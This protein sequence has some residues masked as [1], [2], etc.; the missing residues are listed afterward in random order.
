MKY[1]PEIDGLR[2]LAVLPVIFSHAGFGAFK[3]GYVGVDIFFVISGFLITSILLEENLQASF[4]VVRFYERRA[5]RILPALFL[6]MAV[7]SGLAW[8]SMLPDELENFGQSLFATSAF[9]NNV[10]LMFTAGYWSLASDFKPLLHTWSL[11]VEEQ[12]YIVFPLL[13]VACRRWSMGAL[14]AMFGSIAV[15]S[16]AA[17]EWLSLTRSTMA[18]YLLP[19]RAWELLFGSLVAVG[20]KEVWGASLLAGAREPLSFV[21]LI[22]VLGAI[23]SFG[24]SIRSPSLWLLVPTVGA[25][26][27]ILFAY[28]GTF[29]HRVLASKIAVA[30]GL[31]SYSAYL[32]HQPLFAFARILSHEKP[33]DAL[34]FG[35]CFATIALAYVSWRWVEQ[36]FRRSG[37]PFGR[38]FIFTG[39]FLGS[40]A[41]SAFG[42]F[43]HFGKGIPERVFADSSVTRAGMYIGYNERAFERKVEYFQR[44]GVSRVL[45]HGNSYARDFLNMNLEVFDTGS[46]E[47][48]YRD[49]FAPCL[50]KL[51]GRSARLY[52][53][54]DVIVYAS[55]G[56]G[57]EVACAQRNAAIANA[58]GK[59]I[60]Y[61]G[62]KHFGY[63]LNWLARVPQAERVLQTNA[64]VPAAWDEASQ[65]RATVPQEIFLPIYER[66]IVQDRRMPITD[67][68]GRILSPDRVHLTRDGAVYLGRRVLWDTAYEESIGRPGRKQTMR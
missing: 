19:T 37:S 11:G 51:E 12:F 65:L 53:Q 26:L 4:S 16:L 61:L 55:G 21:G 9:A 10:L 60:F 48:V 56:M 15:L 22:M 50:D 2:A 40:L 54:A 20:S 64:V 17:A 52:E 24:E 59:R 32:W 5:R 46:I 36:P 63:N 30:V 66:V 49:D 29:A 14:A 34:M 31:V 27:I 44:E 28:P 67:E 23:F 42:L 18:F 1:R 13:L 3:G 38:R 68:M 47:F 6:V 33:S 39:A 7:S 58:A 62:G 41:F 45:V 25:V 8:W 35:L 43:L 57:P